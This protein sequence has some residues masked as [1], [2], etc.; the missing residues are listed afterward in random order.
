MTNDERMTKS[1]CQ[2]LLADQVFQ[3][4]SL[5]FRHYL[6][7]LLLKA[8]HDQT[9][10]SEDVC[11]AAGDGIFIRD[12]GDE[13]GHA[14]ARLQQFGGAGFAEAAVNG[15]FLDSDDGA[16]FAG[17]SENCLSI[18]RLYCVHAQD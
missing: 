7:R 4:S 15:M 8:F 11:L 13:E 1:E 12:A 3:W 16:A 6:E 2:N 5:G 9:V 14:D 10:M 18:E 17:G